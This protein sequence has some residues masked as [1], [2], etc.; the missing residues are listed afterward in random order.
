MIYVD[1][2]KL[3][4]PEANLPK[5]WAQLKRGL[6]LDETTGLGKFLGCE[7]DVG[8]ARLENGVLTRVLPAYTGD[9]AAPKGVRPSKEQPASP[10]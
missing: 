1:D 10:K 6:T 7:H 9:G 3:S 8:A 2:F 5:A 4:G